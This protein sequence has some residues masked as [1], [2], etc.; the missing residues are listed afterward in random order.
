[1]KD[2]SSLFGDIKKEEGSLRVRNNR[3]ALVAEIVEATTE[4]DKKNL[5]KMLMIQAN[6][7]KWNEMDLHA[8]L[9]KRTDPNIRN[10]TALVK[11]FAYPRKKN[12]N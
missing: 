3:E 4:K 10:Y 12:E 7:F 1:M 6:M 5:A 11:S 9:K 2:I 8:L